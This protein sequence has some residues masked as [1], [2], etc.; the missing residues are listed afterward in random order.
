MKAGNLPGTVLVSPDCQHAHVV[1]IKKFQQGARPV[2]EQQQCCL[3]QEKTRRGAGKVADC[4]SVQAAIWARRPGPAA[5]I[6]GGAVG[7]G[8][9]I[10]LDIHVACCDGAA[11][12]ARVKR[13]TWGEFGHKILRRTC[14]HLCGMRGC[15]H[16]LLHWAAVTGS[17]DW[18][19][20]P[21]QTPC[22]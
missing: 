10:R 13:G 12:L 5:H 20:S 7:K 15:A 16:H 1:A 19:A 8:A 2:A 18:R 6:Q 14:T 17:G 4:K 3:L 9:T 11:D 21:L 22:V